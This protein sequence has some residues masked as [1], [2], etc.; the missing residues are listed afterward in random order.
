[1]AL[2]SL[3]EAKKYLRVDTSDEDDLING[4]LGT[5]IAL[6][7]D[8]GR[9]NDERWEAINAIPTEEDSRELVNTRAIL[10]MAIKYALGYL[11]EHREE[12]SHEALV[13]TLR[14]L[15]FSMREGVW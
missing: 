1:M 12:A 8:V 6:C 13:F 2:V 9:L 4:L 10:V 15:L 11:Y 14:A 5:A 3:N 7:S